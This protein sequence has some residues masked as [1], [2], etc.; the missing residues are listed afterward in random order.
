MFYRLKK[1]PALKFIVFILSIILCVNFILLQSTYLVLPSTAITPNETKLARNVIK[2]LANKLASKNSFVDIN[3]NHNE[4]A[5]I[6]KLGSHILPN[7]NTVFAT[8]NLGVLIAFSTEVDVLFTRYLNLTCLISQTSQVA[9]LHDCKVGYLPIPGSLVEWLGGRILSMVLGEDFASTANELLANIEYD[10]NGIK[11][12]AKKSTFLK[13]QVNAS[14]GKLG[15]LASTYQQN[16]TIDKAVIQRY[17]D[18]LDKV[19]SEELASY[20]GALFSLAQRRS[21]KNNA[22]EE[23]TAIIWAL[24]IRFGDYQFASLMK[25]KP[26][27]SNLDIPTTRG[28]VDLTQHFIYSAILQQLGDLEIA[29]AIGEAKELLDSL[30]GGSGFSFS[31]LAADKAGL[32]FSD[33]I[34]SNETNAVKAQQLL[35]NITNED[36]YFPFVHDLPDGFRDV[37]YERVLG[38]INSK[39][40]ISVENEIDQRLYQ[41]PLYKNK[42]SK[43]KSEQWSQ[44]HSKEDKKSWYKVDT[45]IHSK[46]SD[47]LFTIDQIAEKANQYGCDA[48]AITDHGDHNLKN[49]LSSQY[50]DAVN[51][52]QAKYNTMTV[53]AGLE[54]NIPPFRGREHVTVILPKTENQQR[55][56]KV[57]RDR[58]DQN[59]RYDKKVLSPKE[60]FTWLNKYGH[61]ES[62]IQPLILYNHPSRKNFQQ[63]ENEH[64]FTYW[65][66]FTPLVIGFSGAPGHQRE[67]GQ[68]NGS[69]GQHIKTV[70]GWDPSV[71]N[72]GGEW[73]KLLQKGYKVW[74]ARAS[75]DFHNTQLDY[76]PCQFSSTHVLSESNEQN[77]ILQAFQSGAYWAQHGNFVKSLAF[78]VETENTLITMGN[79][80][81]V[82]ENELIDVQISVEL[83]AFDWKAEATSLD[84]LELIVITE[85]T[86]TSV[87]LNHFKMIGNKAVV[88][89]PFIVSSN[90]MVFRLRGKNKTSNTATYM[91]YSNPIKLTTY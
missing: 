13:E 31:D 64:D 83:N 61:D 88:S 90:M 57:F 91:F 3:I 62:K 73:D 45:H 59:K 5:A 24:A 82:N 28:R 56:L 35:A 43:N 51:N 41:L 53:M 34:T 14:M 89:A 8:S 47:G 65:R 18:E 16:A 39:N 32:N 20:I 76:W 54:W 78:N 49:V 26:N 50:F 70:N 72:I 4:I 80:A 19:K 36:E 85:N 69:Y 55:N 27:T 22:I 23:N 46:F 9:E 48:I 17:L 87:A 25:L 29:L 15:D 71:A 68:K 1:N 84:E 81:K 75:S 44:A 63:R 11:L 86:I 37:D 38:S 40:Y 10:N 7:T 67:K 33:F 74:A 30:A 2:Q 79:S 52:A 58:F 12:H 42:Q 60:A 21:E 77:D 66:Q 6:A